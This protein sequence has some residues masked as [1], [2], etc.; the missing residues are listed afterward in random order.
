MS[1]GNFDSQTSTFDR[2]VSTVE[3]VGI[4]VATLALGAMAL[5]MS[6]VVQIPVLPWIGATL[7][8]AALATYV[9]LT[10]RSTL[11]VQSPPAPLSAEL[12]EMLEWMRGEISKQNEWARR[13]AQDGEQ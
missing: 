12:V 2:V 9:W 8:L 11:R 3:R 13:Q 5:W 7:I 1:S 6:P 4:P 10:S